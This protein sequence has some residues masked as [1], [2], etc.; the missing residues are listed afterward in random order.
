[1]QLSREEL[2]ALVGFSVVGPWS[3][4]EKPPKKALKTVAAGWWRRRGVPKAAKE[5]AASPSCQEEEAA[6][7][8]GSPFR[9]VARSDLAVL[10]LSLCL[11]EVRRA[12]PPSFPLR[13]GRLGRPP[14][15]WGA[16]RAAEPGPV[17]EGGRV[18]GQPAASN[19]AGGGLWRVRGAV[20]PLPV[21]HSSRSVKPLRGWLMLLTGK[22]TFFFLREADSFWVWVMVNSYCE[23]WIYLRLLKKEQFACHQDLLCTAA[24]NGMRAEAGLVPSGCMAWVSRE[25][26]VLV[27]SAGLYLGS[28]ESSS[29][30]ACAF[31]GWFGLCQATLS[32]SLPLGG[33]RVVQCI[34]VLSVCFGFGFVCFVFLEIGV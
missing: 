4:S 12:G 1:M 18:C 7:A 3:L 33:G 13:R 30:R 25:E 20:K 34:C 5:P 16:G 19:T 17:G 29:R 15:P 32:F 24:L 28:E 2:G 6:A 23:L 8:G 26:Q 14:F 9:A 22:R 21:S 10:C 27:Q 11:R 31:F